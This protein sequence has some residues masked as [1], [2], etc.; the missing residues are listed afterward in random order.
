ML[1]YCSEK[2]GNFGIVYFLLKMA[3]LA[4]YSFAKNGFG[5][6]DSEGMKLG[7]SPIYIQQHW[8]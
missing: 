8:G 2:I 7:I 6:Y 5:A 3:I 1:N 4:V